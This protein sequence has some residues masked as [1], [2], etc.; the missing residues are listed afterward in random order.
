QI[1]VEVDMAHADPSLLA[2][3]SPADLLWSRLRELHRFGPTTTSK[4][5]ARKRPRLIPVYD[6]V[7][8]RAFQMNG[9]GA[10][11]TFW[12]ESLTAHDRSLHEYLLSLRAEA[13][14]A[15]DISALRVLD[16]VVWMHYRDLE[17][18]QEQVGE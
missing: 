4:L 2:P 14:L 5:M 11:W 13:G 18:D 1:P 6:S 17:E 3:G 7:I 8:R 12:H 9:S 10:Q 15:D 16:I